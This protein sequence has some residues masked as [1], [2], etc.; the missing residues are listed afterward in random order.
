MLDNNKYIDPLEKLFRQK[1][2][3]YNIPFHEADWQDMEK[4]LS[5]MDEQASHRNRW[6]WAV[7]ASILVFSLLGYFTYE[8]STRIN[9]LTEQL[10][11]DAPVIG[12]ST[13]HKSE[14]YGYDASEG[15][16]QTTRQ[17]NQ[18]GETSAESIAQPDGQPRQTANRRPLPV[19]NKPAVDKSVVIRSY[20]LIADDSLSN[21]LYVS[22]INCTA[23]GISEPS[24]E[25]HLNIRTQGYLPQAPDT[26]STLADATDLTPL[27]DEEKVSTRLSRVTLSFV[28]GPDLSTVGS[29]SDFYD[30]GYKLGIALEYNLTSKLSVSAGFIQSEVRYR[31]QGNE[32]KPPYGYWTDGIVPTQT[33]GECLLFD[34]PISLKYRFLDF[35]HSHV[36]VGAGLSSYIMQSEDYRFSY[37]GNRSDLVQG[38]YGETGSRHWFS[39]VGF[40]IGYELDLHPNWSLRVE[41]FMSIPLKEVGWGNVKLYSLGNFISLNYKL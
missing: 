9:Q 27:G 16:T 20:A 6:R 5:V 30:P 24:V 1:A 26:A 19:K 23:C 21:E 7:A 13:P 34:I 14:T 10:N 11:R 38:W 31:A 36:Y 40:S 22:E 15:Q 17:N 3:D 39:N 41:P 28:A 2:E 29:F 8:N 25:S 18:Q 35:K 4:R 12:Q 32:Y 33:I 37:E